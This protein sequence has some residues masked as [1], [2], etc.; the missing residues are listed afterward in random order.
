MYVVET[1]PSV[2]VLYTEPSP[3][4]RKEKPFE[5]KNQHLIYLPPD[6]ADVLPFANQ[7]LLP[8]LTAVLNLSKSILGIP[9]I[10]SDYASKE[11]SMI[12]KSKIVTLGNPS[13]ALTTEYSR[14]ANATTG[15]DV[16][17]GEAGAGTHLRGLGMLGSFL[18]IHGVTNE[19]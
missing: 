19:R 16:S 9:I 2:C 3:Q 4:E 18:K 7:I 10:F 13:F 1:E 17:V 11:K 8:H 14:N 6:S 5:R 15:N 12:F